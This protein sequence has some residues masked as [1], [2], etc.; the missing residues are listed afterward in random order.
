MTGVQTCALPIYCDQVYPEKLIL[1]ERKKLFYSHNPWRC[2]GTKIMQTESSTK[3]ACLFL[4]LRS[5]FK[6]ERRFRFVR[7]L[8]KLEGVK[9]NTPADD[10]Q[11]YRL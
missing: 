9:A 4:M 7:E 11:L 8:Q 10:S 5:F 3:Y 6:G 2:L 1:F